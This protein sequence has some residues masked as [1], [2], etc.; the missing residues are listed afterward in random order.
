MKKIR[1]VEL[2]SFDGSISAAMQ[3]M[4]NSKAIYNEQFKSIKIQSITL[5][6]HQLLNGM[7]PKFPYTLAIVVFEVEEKERA[8]E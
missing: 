5:G 7:Y 8:N 1:V 4:I 2:S 3:Y 6:T